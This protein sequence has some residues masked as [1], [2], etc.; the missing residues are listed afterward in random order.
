MSMEQAERYQNM[1]GDADWQKTAAFIV[2]RN[3]GDKLAAAMS[4]LSDAQIFVERPAFKDDVRQMMNK[5]KYLIDQARDD[6]SALR[7]MIV[8][9]FDKMGVI[10]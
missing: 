3:G 1:F 4:I 5:A 9:E 2:E 7:N 10:R 6:Q 8:G